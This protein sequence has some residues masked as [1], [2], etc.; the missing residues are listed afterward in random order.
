PRFPDRAP[1]PKRPPNGS[2]AASLEH[3]VRYDEARQPCRCSPIFAAWVRSD[4]THFSAH[5]HPRG[6][7]L[8]THNLRRRDWTDAA[9]ASEPIL[10]VPT[11][12]YVVSAAFL[13]Q[14]NISSSLVRSAPGA[15][16]VT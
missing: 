10:Q 1:T 11:G 13:T 14:S 6:R 16:S 9:H 7:G 5:P 15:T 8:T 4:R 2:C 3:Q 12:W